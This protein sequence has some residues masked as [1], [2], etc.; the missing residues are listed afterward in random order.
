[1]ARLDR[2]SGAVGRNQ[3][4]V[5]EFVL[6]DRDV[7]EIARAN[8]ALRAHADGGVDAVAADRGAVGYVVEPYGR[9]GV[10]TRNTRAAVVDVLEAE[11]L[12][13]DIRCA[14]KEGAGPGQDGVAG[15]VALA[16]G[17]P[18]PR[19]ARAAHGEA[20]LI[21]PQVKA[22]PSADVFVHAWAELD[23]VA[24]LHGGEHDAAAGPNLVKRRSKFG[25]C[26]AAR[27][28][29]RRRLRRIL[30]PGGVAGG[31][32]GRREQAHEDRD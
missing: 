18:Q 31:Q 21:E 2:R 5:D 12:E 20:F 7:L 23:C 11:M 3:A 32:H 26:V 24:R 16:A 9:Q 27:N 28:L 6:R 25:I 14:E 8:E 15:R 29:V 17:L 10:R 30:G 1:M 19:V 13:R 4:D 22:I